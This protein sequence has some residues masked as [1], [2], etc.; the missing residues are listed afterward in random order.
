MNY[1]SYLPESKRRGFW[2]VFFDIVLVIVTLLV[3]G[4]LVVSYFAPY[5]EP[6]VRWESAFFGL[7]AP[8]LMLCNLLL[9]LLW[10]I[11]WR[12]WL[13]IPLLAFLPGLLFAGRFIQFD[14]LTDY[15]PEERGRDE[16]VVLTYNTHGFFKPGKDGRNTPT[17]DSI[18]AYIHRVDPDVICFQEFETIRNSDSKRIDELLDRWKYRTIF[19]SVGNVGYGWGI[20]VFSKHPLFDSRSVSFAGTNNS[21][22]YV[23]MEF[24]GDTVRLFNTHLQSN[25]ITEERRLQMENIDIDSHTDELIKEVG[26]TLRNSFRKRA[27]QADSLSAFISRSPWPVVVTGDFNDTPMSYTYDTM[28]GGLDD[29]FRKKGKGYGYTFNNLFR[30]LRIDYILVSPAITT[31]GYRSDQ[32]PWSDHNPVWVRLKMS[33]K[34]K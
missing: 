27:V 3:S 29:T 34:D 14:I 26:S 22:Q 19:I 33:E 2:A 15:T 7:A 20:A 23:D 13:I 25:Y 24:R 21:A 17:V 16:L 28:T 6:S 11:R 30:M 32:L 10:T 12:R 1:G 5:T 31:L 18:S 4:G 9:L 8:V